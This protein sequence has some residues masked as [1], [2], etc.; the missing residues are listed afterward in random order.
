MAWATPPIVAVGDIATA[1]NWNILANNESYLLPGTTL[2]TKPYCPVGVTTYS[3][4]TSVAALDTT[5]LMCPFVMGSSGQIEFEF[6]TRWYNAGTGNLDM[7]AALFNSGG[8][9]VSSSY[10]SYMSYGP[11]NWVLTYRVLASGTPG[12]SYSW[13]PG[14][15]VGAGNSG[16]VYAGGS[17][18]ALIT[19]RSV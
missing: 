6:T 3:V 19:I 9:E 10:R 17:V 1:A 14:A 8:T 11:T 2:G 12:T 7:Y 13:G 18:Q 16:Q 5:N 15:F 4:S